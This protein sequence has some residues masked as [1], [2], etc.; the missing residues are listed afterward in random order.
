MRQEGEQRVRRG[1]VVTTADEG[2][3]GK[4]LPSLASAQSRKPDDGCGHTSSVKVHCCVRVLRVRHKCARVVGG[5]WWVVGGGC[6]GGV[7]VGVGG[8]GGGGADR[9]ITRVS[10]DTCACVHLI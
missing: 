8:G 7:G 10:V 1:D 6:G 5:G 2:R 4:H 9:G 3:T